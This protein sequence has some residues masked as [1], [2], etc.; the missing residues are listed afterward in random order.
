MLIYK[1]QVEIAM[2]ALKKQKKKTILLTVAGIGVTAS[3]T[4]L[5]F[6]FK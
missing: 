6:S 1:E 4:F 3:L 2:I 5:L